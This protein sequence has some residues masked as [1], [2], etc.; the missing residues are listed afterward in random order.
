MPYAPVCPHDP[1]EEIGP[2]LFMVRGSVRMNRLIRITRN[3]AI[4]RHGEELCLVNPIRLREAE[5]NKLRD[6]GRVRNIVRLGPFHG[7]DDPYY[8]DRFEAPLWAPGKSEAYPEPQI[9]HVLRPGGELP[10]SDA[11]LF[12]FEGTVQPEAALLVRRGKHTLLTCDA[13]Q[14]YGDY[15]HNN[16]LARCMLPFLGFPKTTVVG[17]IWLKVM[18]PQGASLEGEFRRLLELEF[19]R[20]L[21]AHGSLLRG[22]ARA[23][24]SA[25]VDR[26][27]RKGS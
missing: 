4:I 17:P 1:I 12:R 19:E 9:D 6:L 13:I 15:R 21:S 18:T 23:A 3:M 2:D 8:V 5:E 27:F 14:H 26:A 20:L 11:E 24:V 10:V 7:L 22:G 25:A 16:L